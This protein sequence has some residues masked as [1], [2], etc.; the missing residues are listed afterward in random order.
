MVTTSS[1]ATTLGAGSGIDIPT[2]VTSLVDA[3][4]AIKKQQLTS[5]QETLSAQISAVS[6]L[7]S[8]ITGFASALTSLV[9]G[10]SLATQ[11]TS[12]NP[13]AVKASTATGATL[14]ALS[15]RMTVGAIAAG[16]V[17]ATGRLATTDTYGDGTGSFTLQFGTASVDGNGQMSL[18]NPGQAIS[19]PITKAD[20]SLSDIAAA[21]NGAAKGIT[22]SVIGD[23][24]GDG[25]RLV[26]RGP[27]GAGSAFTL[28]SDDPALAAVGVSGTS[29]GAAVQVQARDAQITL[30][31]VSFSRGTNTISDLI[32]GVKLELLDTTTSPVLLT[33]APATSNIVQ[34]VS[35]V[36]DTYNQ[37]F[38]TIKTD[39][40]P[41][42]GA[43]R[44]DPSVSAMKRRLQGLTLTK[45]VPDDGS[46]APRTL[47][48]IGV[49]TNRDG[50]LKVDATRLVAVAAQ[51]PGQLEK[52][53]AAG[54]GATEKGL[55]AA[56]NA[57]A[58]EAGSTSVGLGAAEQRYSKARSTL[59]D[60]Q[61]KA[62]E[63]ATAMRERLTRQ[64]A[65]MDARVAAYKSTQTFLQQQIDAW[66]A[67]S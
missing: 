21:I 66:N 55:S 20:A 47:A 2:L 14:G 65:S 54:T 33:S 23:G 62:T 32:P 1:I 29:G 50:T 36:V 58:A 18:A 13:G 11:P 44:T 17:A 39:T 56:L 19:I 6:E 48:E 38:A 45:L 42:T 61:S 5:R 27:T 67:K 59:T 41:I 25:Q 12:S 35:D 52:I 15:A 24:D 57:I 4:Y 63:E 7:R 51:Y 40:D 30:D 22:A 34:A 43:L 49:G 28:T 31:G 9:K 46:G 16:Q 10:G 53:F 64:F 37:L 60:Q 8:G 3:Q 26:L